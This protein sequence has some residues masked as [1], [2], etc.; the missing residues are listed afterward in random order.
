MKPPFT[1]LFFMNINNNGFL[2]RLAA[3]LCRFILGCGILRCIK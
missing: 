1:I 2:A 3:I